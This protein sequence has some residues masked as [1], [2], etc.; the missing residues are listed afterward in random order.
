[1]LATFVVISP[2]AAQDLSPVTTMLTS[3]GTALTGPVG[4]AL[5]LVALAA[6]GILFLTGRMNWLYAGSVVVGLVILF[7]AATIL[8]GF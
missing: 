1:M 7:G 5:G 2:A 4:R 6:V 3:I 8:A